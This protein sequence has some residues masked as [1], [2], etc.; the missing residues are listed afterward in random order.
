MNTSTVLVLPAWYP[1]AREPLAGP[2]VRDHALAAA[3]FG[4]RMVV[5][6]DEGSR[7]DI[8]R[9]YELREER[10]RGL[11]IFRLSY[12]PSTG[13]LAYLPGVLEVT[14]RLRRESV[15]VDVL[16]AHV[17]R[18]GWAAVI[19]GRLIRRPAVITEHSTE[20]V[21]RTIT[22]GALRRARISFP[23]ASL[24]CPVS[25]HLRRAIEA[26]GIHAHFRVVPN[27]VDT[28]LFHPTSEPIRATPTRL[29]NVGLHIERK[30]LDV[31]LRAFAT[32]A[33]HRRELTLDLVGDGPLTPSLKE[34]AVALGIGDRVRFMGAAKPAEI[35]RILG[36]ADVFV[37]SSLSE[38]GPIVVLE[39]LCCGVPVASTSVGSVPDVIGA[40]GALATPGDVAGLARAIEAVLDAFDGYD[41]TEIAE[42]AAA[43]ASFEAVG[44]VWDEIY[45]SLSKMRNPED[46]AP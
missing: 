23:R 3:D 20:W 15:S 19:V 37:L 33:E 9:L 32:I 44:R 7:D 34:L 21:D 38:T 24:V 26:Y 25:E 10:D 5:V 12:R 31:L 18:M 45:R 28:R 39:A 42:R 41:R 29:L 2:Y 46:V 4:H 30:G 22:P 36:T 1:T 16:H 27:T 17:H 8:R 6:V 40:D 13:T 14:R 35:A 43:R 11:R